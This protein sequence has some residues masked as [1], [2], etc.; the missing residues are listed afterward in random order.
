M[1]IS[2][3]RKLGIVQL[4]AISLALVGPTLVLAANVQAI[5]SVT[6]WPIWSVF[7]IGAG[8]IALVAYSISRLIGA[9]GTGASAYHITTVALGRHWGRCVGFSLCGA[10]MFFALATPSATIGFLEDLLH[11]PVFEEPLWRSLLGFGLVCLAG[12]IVSLSS[13]RVS[14]VLLAIEG[15]GIMLMFVLCG[16]IVFVRPSGPP[17]VTATAM[18]TH[19]ISGLVAGVVVAFLSWAG[20]ESCLSVHAGGEGAT[21]RTLLSLYGNI[22]ITSI[23]FIAVSWIIQRGFAD[24]LGG[25]PFLAQTQNTLSALAGAYVSVWC[26]IGFG[27]AAI[28][29]A[30]ACLM[31]SLTAAGNIAASLFAEEGRRVNCNIVV[32]LFIALSQIIIPWVPHMPRSPVALY[33]LFG[34]AAAVCIMVSYQMIQIAFIRALIRGLVKGPRIELIVPVVCMVIICVV[35]VTNLLQSEAGLLSTLM[36]AAWCSVGFLLGGYGY[37]SGTL[38]QE[39]GL[40]K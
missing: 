26:A 4:V 2:E 35:L 29:S 19:H 23:L 14:W 40:C 9:L 33:G 16:A 7:F 1:N 11:A 20:F 13:R 18:H 24:R 12:G 34:A 10:Y 28:C 31:A 39:K 3:K 38:G 8:S 37:V 32:F 21:R 5:V 25:N 27:V 17:A 36:G 30:F 22:L 15:G 6:D